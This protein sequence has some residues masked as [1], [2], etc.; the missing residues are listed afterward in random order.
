MREGQSKSFEFR[1]VEGKRQR[2]PQAE[3]E[4]DERYRVHERYE[5]KWDGEKEY[6][7]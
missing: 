4:A 2:D 7:K 1:N 3:M 5:E 6:D